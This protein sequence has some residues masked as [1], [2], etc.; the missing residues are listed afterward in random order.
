MRDTIR[1]SDL[2]D[3]ALSCGLSVQYD[4][5]LYRVAR[6]SSGGLVYMFPGSAACPAGTKRDCMAYLCGFAAARRLCREGRP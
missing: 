3:L 4:H 5:G 6:P 1:E 2:H